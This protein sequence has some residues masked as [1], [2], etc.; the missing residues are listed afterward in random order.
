MKIT[1]KELQDNPSLRYVFKEMFLNLCR[2]KHV[3]YP[4]FDLSIDSTGTSHCS[5]SL[6]NF[7]YEEVEEID[8]KDCVAYGINMFTPKEDLP[9]ELKEGMPTRYFQCGIRR[10]LKD[11]LDYESSFSVMFCEIEK[12]EQK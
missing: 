3:L 1:F 2:E 5:I 7:I 8:E 6:K 9:I 12:K 10:F 11:R 4:R